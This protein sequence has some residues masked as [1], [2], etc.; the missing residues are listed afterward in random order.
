MLQTIE[1]TAPSKK[2]NGLHYAFIICLGGFLTQAIVLSCQRLPAVALEPIRQTLGVS[3]ADVGLITSVFM[4]FYAGLS[5]VWGMLGDKIGTRWAMTIACG[6]ASIGA[7]LERADIGLVIYTGALH[8]D[9]MGDYTELHLQAVKRGIPTLT[10]IDTALAAVGLLE[11]QLTE[12]S[13]ELVDISAIG[14]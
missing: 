12:D 9:T 7:L 1:D 10:S 14:M 13:T 2:G 6:L 3:Y 4:I 5:I 8:D 11:D